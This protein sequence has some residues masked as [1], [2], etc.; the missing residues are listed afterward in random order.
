VPLD[1]LPES[2]A[3]YEPIVAKA[4]ARDPDERYSCAEEFLAALEDVAL[5][6]T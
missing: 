3:Q 5:A 2:V 6:A 1:P 4:L